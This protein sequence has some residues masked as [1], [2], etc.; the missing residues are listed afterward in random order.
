MQARCALFFLEQ[1]LLVCGWQGSRRT[2]RDLR[3]YRPAALRVLW[4]EAP[5]YFEGFEGGNEKQM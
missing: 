3:P 1:V 4:I 2:R 5:A